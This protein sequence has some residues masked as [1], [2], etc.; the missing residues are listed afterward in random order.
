MHHG[1]SSSSTVPIHSSKG[2]TLQSSCFKQ[3]ASLP[4]KGGFTATGIT[5][6]RPLRS[7]QAL[8]RVQHPRDPDSTVHTQVGHPGAH[9]ETAELLDVGGL[10][11]GHERGGTTGTMSHWHAKEPQQSQEQY[12]MDGS[13]HCAMN[14][15]AWGVQ[16]LQSSSRPHHSNPSD[17]H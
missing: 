14:P 12:G 17:W 9:R 10:G 2:C 11:V 7:R 3:E 8:H 6:L 16:T 1:C 15:T 13:L 4:G 5:Q